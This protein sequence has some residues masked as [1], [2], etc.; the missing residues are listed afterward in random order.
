MKLQFIFLALS[1]EML[2]FGDVNVAEQWET[3]INAFVANL[4][5]LK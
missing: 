1:V 2:P 5:V 3:L 4:K